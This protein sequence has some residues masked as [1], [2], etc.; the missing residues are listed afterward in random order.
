MLRFLN[1]PFLVLFLSARILVITPPNSLTPYFSHFL[2]PFI[3]VKRKGQLRDV[4]KRELDQVVGC[5]SFPFLVLPLPLRSHFHTYMALSVCWQNPVSGGKTGVE[6]GALAATL[7]G[8]SGR[9]RK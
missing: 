5:L 9:I 7:V 6:Q 3:V 4:P 1:P 2:F 8:G